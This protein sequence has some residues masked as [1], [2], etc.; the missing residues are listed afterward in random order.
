MP[1]GNAAVCG[2]WRKVVGASNRVPLALFGH[3]DAA[4]NEPRS[5]EAPTSVITYLVNL[6]GG[7]ASVLPEG[8]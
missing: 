5:L 8:A 4:I 1:S 3:A 7:S 6:Q 2:R